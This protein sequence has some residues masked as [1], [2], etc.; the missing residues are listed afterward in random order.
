MPHFSFVVRQILEILMVRVQ[1][2]KKNKYYLY[3]LVISAHLFFGIFIHK[4][5]CFLIEPC[6]F[7][8][9]Q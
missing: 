4:S 8:E 9:L 7:H 6:I 3:L 1:S 2:G 5:R